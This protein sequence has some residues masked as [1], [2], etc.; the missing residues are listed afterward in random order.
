MSQVMSLRLS[1]SQMERLGRVARRHEKRPS[2]M[3]AVL[4]EEALRMAE[5]SH[6]RFWETAAGR[7]AYISG[8]RL[9]VWMVTW[10][11]REYGG[12]IAAAAQHLQESQRRIQA[13]LDYAAAYPDEIDQLIA[14]NLAVTFEDIKRMIP[15]ATQSTMTEET[16]PEP[17]AAA[18]A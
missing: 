12:D 15:N 7:R 4:L 18:T 16:L 11:V 1:E 9:S 13:A 8:T 14:D 3:A 6:I 17:D 10:I 2:Q 5:H